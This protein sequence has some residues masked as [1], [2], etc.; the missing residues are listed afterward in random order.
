MVVNPENKPTYGSVSQK[1]DAWSSEHASAGF[2]TKLKSKFGRHDYW[3]VIYQ[4]LS[5]QLPV[6]MNGWNKCK[7][8][9]KSQ[10]I[11]LDIIYFPATS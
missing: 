9:V 4:T 3:D 7:L 1:D 5:V 2:Q 8:I 6:C 10:G 11:V